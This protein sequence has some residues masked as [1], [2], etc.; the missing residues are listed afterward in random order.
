MILYIGNILSSKGMNPSPVEL[1]RNE[2][3]KSSKIKMIVASNKKN[4]IF[5][6]L[7]MNYIYWRNYKKVSLMFIDVYS[8]KAFYF[9]FYFALISKFLSLKYIPIIHGGNIELRI[10]KSKSMTKFVFKNSNINISPS[11]YV[12]RI[13]K[14]NN[15]AVKYIPNCINSSLYKFKKRQKFRPRIIWLRSFHEIYNPDMAINVFKIIS[16]C[17]RKTKLTMIGP[18]KDGSLKHCQQLSKKYRIDHNI[19]FLGYQSKTKWIKIAR[20]HDIFINTSKIDNMPVSVIEMMALGLPIVSTDV[21][22]IPFLLEH[23]KNSLLVKNNDVENMAYQIKYLIKDPHIAGQISMKAF[24][25]SK[26]FS[27]DLIIPE[28]SKIINKYS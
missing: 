13:F 10:K 8:T 12:Y 16:S 18:D 25:D 21:G 9:T 15:F 24:E 2:I 1:I 28:W 19:D 20:D 3:Y 5:R 6:F 23:G 14:K 26:S 27:T 17:Y 22:G 7:H 11:I 4:I